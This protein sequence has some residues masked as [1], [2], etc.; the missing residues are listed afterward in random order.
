MTE[1]LTLWMKQS[2]PNAYEREIHRT[3]SLISHI[4]MIFIWILITKARSRI[5]Q[6]QDQ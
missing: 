6:E 1:N 5:T 2:N 3:I 4:T